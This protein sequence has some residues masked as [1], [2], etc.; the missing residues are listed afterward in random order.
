MQLVRHLAACDAEPVGQVG[1][2]AAVV[3]GGGVDCAGEPEGVFTDG[4]QSD[5]VGLEEV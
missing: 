1:G 4:Q 5:I 3:V 2:A